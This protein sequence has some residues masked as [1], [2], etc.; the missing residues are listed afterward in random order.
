MGL[1]NRWRDDH[2]RHHNDML[3]YMGQDRVESVQKIVRSV[4]EDL[5]SYTN[6][7]KALKLS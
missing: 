5:T 1:S 7:C 4:L 6:V 2:V 3:T